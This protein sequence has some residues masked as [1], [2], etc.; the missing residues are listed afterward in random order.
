MGG[1]AAST[2]LRSRQALAARAT[3]AAQNFAFRARRAVV[4][5]SGWLL[6]AV[7]A[8]L[9][10]ANW[11]AIP[12]YQRWLGDYFDDTAKFDALK[13]F[14][15]AL[16]AALIGATAIASSFVLFAT[17]TN[18][19]RT[20]HG[21]FRRLGSDARLLLSFATTFGIAFA[22]AAGSLA[23]DQ[24]WAA[25]L[26]F[27]AVE[28]AFA[29]L[30]LFAFAYGRA[31]KLIN[32][33]E[34]LGIVVG[35][36]RKTMRAWAKRADRAAHLIPPPAGEE[37]DFPPPGERPDAARMM[38]FRSNPAWD[39]AVKQGIR[40]A[41]G[42]SRHYAGQ[43]DYEVSGAALQA[44][45]SLNQLYVAAKGKT[46]FAN[47]V[48]IEN[49]LVTDAV[50]NVSLEQ[51]SQNVRLALSRDDNQLVE[52]N[53]SAFAALSTTY[54]SIDYPG[55]GSPKT[56]ALL[57]AH[58]LGDAVTSIVRHDMP[59]SVM[60]GLRIM[61]TQAIAIMWSSS[62]TDGVALVDKI[63]QLGVVGVAQEKLRPVTL[64]AIEQISELTLRLLHFDQHRLEFA[65][66]NLRDAARLIADFFLEV[67]EQPLSNTHSTFLGPYYSSVSYTSL[68][69]RLTEIVNAAIKDD[70]DKDAANNLTANLATWSEKLA[71]PQKEL[72][73]KS[74]EKRLHFTFDV[75]T[76]VVGIVEILLAGATAPACEPRN[77][78]KLRKNAL[79]LLY[80]LSWLPRDKEAAQFLQRFHISDRLFE[81]ALAAR[82]RAADDVYDAARSM[83]IRWSMEAGAQVTAW[84]ILEK[85]L[86]ALITLALLNEGE[87]ARLKAEVSEA[88][89]REGAPDEKQRA[90]AANGL[91]RVARELRPQAFPRDR[92]DALLSQC[93]RADATALL[94]D[95]AAL[96][97]PVEGA[98]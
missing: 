80:T 52:Q 54:L 15:L 64:T 40:Y 1:R 32:P 23:P 79:H 28:G 68:R 12:P 88:L 81:T 94:T 49:P 93:N 43:G 74:V 53:L 72:L 6:V 33:F 82:Q 3:F 2:K 35:D 67:P 24:S 46:F 70:A 59:D 97:S 86:V 31:L 45:V 51:I 63:G 14:V 27:G 85:G 10:V 39:Q 92:V 16:G 75:I 78:D 17:Q 13:N 62:P 30:A 48:L 61:G 21:L 84:S 96:L 4:R 47:N 77:A 26:I 57:A 71:E 18:V 55:A 36:V 7:V 11:F 9:G 69:A 44:V 22:I 38:F 25:G 73:L 41:I 98:N 34:Q 5:R 66:D 37:A 20:P 19:E 65:F 29:T 60:V 90:R 56:H 42:Y 50:V 8:G 58:Y 91:R 83:I 95:I 76:W 89:C 87:P